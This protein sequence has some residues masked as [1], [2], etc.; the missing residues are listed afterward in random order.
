MTQSKAYTMSDQSLTKN[1]MITLKN[2]WAGYEK[3]PILEE[4]NLT[5]NEQDFIGI[6]GPNGGGKTTLLKVLLGLIKPFQG[7][8]NIMGYSPEKGRKYMGYVPQIFEFDRHFPLKVEDVVKMGR[9]S[10][11]RLFQRYNQKDKEK[12][13]QSLEAVGLLNLYKNSIG[14][15]SGGQRQRVYIARALACDPQIL[16]LDEPTA[17]VDPQSQKDIYELLKELNKTITILMISHDMGAVSR[18]VKTVACLNRRLYYHQ[19]KLIT[20]E[21][22]E[23]TYQCP[24]DLVAHGIPHRVFSEHSCV[25][26]D[27]NHDHSCP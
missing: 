8:I 13:I 16:L 25:E 2:I 4:I 23:N 27:H 1:E 7:T 3:N 22:L 10:R 14:E 12:V 9:L 21:M 6:I 20:A 11:N 17:S 26:N 19:D 18:Y 5:V 15:L 24:I